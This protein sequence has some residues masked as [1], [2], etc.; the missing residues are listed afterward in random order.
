M[1]EIFMNKINITFFICFF[2]Q[3][4][5]LHRIKTFQNSAVKCLATISIMPKQNNGANK[6]LNGFQ[7]RRIYFT[8]DYAIDETFSARFRL[9]SDQT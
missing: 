5:Q 9:E 2:L 3:D 1:K 4:L 6:D 8:T 7:F